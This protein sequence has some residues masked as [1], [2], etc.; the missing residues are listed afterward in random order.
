MTGI[1]RALAVLVDPSES[2]YL[3][4]GTGSF[5][6]EHS[7]VDIVMS[8]SRRYLA[9]GSPRN[10]PTSD[11]HGTKAWYPPDSTGGSARDIM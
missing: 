10:I 1:I 2:G 11:R 3:Q 5:Y 6:R 9:L 8:P 4:V 7:A